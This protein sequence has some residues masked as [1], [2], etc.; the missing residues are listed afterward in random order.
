MR[1]LLILKQ[2]INGSFSSSH[3]GV[4]AT[5]VSVSNSSVPF[6][7]SSRRHAVYAPLIEEEAESVVFPREGPGISHGL[8]WSLAGKGVIVKD[9]AFQNLK[10]SELHQK[11]AT[12]AEGMFSKELQKFRKHGSVNFR[13]RSRFTYR[14]FRRY[15]F[16]MGAIGS[17]PKCNFKVRVISDTP[18]VLSFSDVL[19]GTPT[20][21]VSHDSCPLT[22]YVASS[23]STSAAD[24]LGLGSQAKALSALS[25]PIISSRGGLL[26]SA[27]LLV[28]GDSVILLLA[29]E[30]AIQSCSGLFVSADAGAILSSEGA[31]ALGKLG[32]YGSWLVSSGA[33]PAVSKL[34]PG[35]SVQG[36]DL[37]NLVQS[38]LK[39]NIPK[40]QPKGGYLQGRYKTFLSSKFQ[41]LPEEFSF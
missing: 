23:L 18:A 35:S 16:I 37:I 30:D 29:S 10:R 28:S 3:R 41:E 19:W 40:F 4:S 21:G 32:Q 27:R 17:S 22:I 20:R 7:L 31:P 6:P 9:K 34:S 38:T 26:L 12:V 36:K 24:A 39:E 15:L 14:P 33:I 2:F 8:N 25:G 13:N 11:G 5:A 1:N